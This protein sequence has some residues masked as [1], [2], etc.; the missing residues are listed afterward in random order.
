MLAPVQHPDGGSMTHA[1]NVATLPGL[2]AAP[3]AVP[4]PAN[5]PAIMVTTP[6]SGA[7]DELMPD[8]V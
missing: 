4:V 8:I 5:L 6:T 7:N 3:S 2:T 1:Q